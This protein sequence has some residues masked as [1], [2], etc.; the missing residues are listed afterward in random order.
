ML[1]QRIEQ[2]LEQIALDP[3]S[4]QLH[5]QLYSLYRRAGREEL[6]REELNKAF[7]LCPYDLDIQVNYYSSPPLQLIKFFSTAFTDHRSIPIFHHA[8]FHNSRIIALIEGGELVVWDTSS[9]RPKRRIY[10]GPDVFLFTVSSS[11][12]IL[13]NRRNLLQ[14]RSLCDF[15]VLDQFSF[16]TQGI[17]K[18]EYSEEEERFYVL[19]D[20]CLEVWQLRG[21]RLEWLLPRLKEDGSGMLSFALSGDGK[22]F[23]TVDLK[24]VTLWR[25]KS[26][27]FLD[28]FPLP[29]EVGNC[30]ILEDNL[31]SCFLEDGGR[32]ALIFLKNILEVEFSSPLNF[33]FISLPEK[34]IGS[35]FFLDNG[36]RG[37]AQSRR[38]FFYFS[39]HNHSVQVV[40]TFPLVSS[41]KRCFF[42]KAYAF[43]SDG[44]E[45]RIFDI[46]RQRIVRCISFPHGSI[47]CG[48]GGVFVLRECKIYSVVPETGQ[49]DRVGVVERGNGG[50]FRIGFSSGKERG[51][52]FIQKEGNRLYFVFLDM[53]L[54]F[55]QRWSLE[56]EFV[57][58]LVLSYCHFQISPAGEHFFIL[59]FLKRTFYFFEFNS[60]KWELKWSRDEVDYAIFFAFSQIWIHRCDRIL[61]LDYEGRSSRP[62]VKMPF[63]AKI[64]EVV[65]REESDFIVFTS[66]VRKEGED[67]AHYYLMCYRGGERRIYFSP[68][69]YLPVG[70]GILEG[71]RV[72]VCDSY[73]RF[74]YYAFHSSCIE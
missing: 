71:A 36:R 35:L 34:D 58:D 21:G 20:S 19:R 25:N 49:M 40:Q 33:R 6:A 48:L 56:G 63:R 30:E 31:P 70:L 12:L 61:V 51:I 10:V 44:E 38:R 42:W 11:Y 5:F 68:L 54:N 24:K 60:P 72:V 39:I 3:L 64:L 59:D 26:F 9:F 23:L 46:N 22:Y 57:S 55:L 4:P 52:H 69:P 8:D 45:I 62:V 73:G 65:F 16:E 50:E 27:T 29:L 67:A 43:L 28:S 32:R 17:Q 37:I 15:Q 53:E 7:A 1:H 66:E 41:V 13:V 2:L 18:L 14:F 74:S 47:F